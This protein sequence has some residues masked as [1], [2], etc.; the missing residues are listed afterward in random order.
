MSIID[1]FNYF[2]LKKQLKNL[3]PKTLSAYKGFVIPFIQFI[4][5]SA[6]IMDIT[7]G[8][9]QEYI[10]MLYQRPLSSATRATYIRHIKSFLRWLKD[11]YSIPVALSEIEI[12]KAGKKNV[13][14]LTPEEIRT[15]FSC[16]KAETDWLRFRNCAIISLMLDSGLRQNEVA[17]LFWKDIYPTYAIVRGKGDKERFV[18]LG[19]LTKEFLQ[20]YRREC[21]FSSEFV[22]VERRGAP[23]SNNAIKLFVQKIKH[24]S[25][26]DFSSHKLRHNFATNYCID[27]LERT[28][29]CDAY[30]LKVLMGHEDVKTTEKYMHYAQGLIASKN[31]CSHLDAVFGVQNPSHN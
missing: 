27:S 18:P 13:R 28:G 29:Q 7:T 22:F 4:G 1:S 31:N 30:T 8:K 19:A 5:L 15:L 10:Y 9:V 25:G 23:M 12:P 2:I 16:I 21:P 3:S 26:I 14:I 17:T 24:Q 20:D 11:Y 6:D